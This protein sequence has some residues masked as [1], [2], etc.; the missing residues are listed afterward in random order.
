MAFKRYIRKHGKKLG[1]YYYENV[2]GNDGSVKTIYLGTNPSHHAKHR[3][4]KPLFFLILVLLLILVFGASLFLLQNKSY[5]IKKVKSQQADFDIDQILLK[6][7][8]KSNEFIEKQ[9]RI[10]NT[11]SEQ[12]A[13]SIEVYGLSDIIKT[14]SPSFVIKPGQTKVVNL[15]FSSYIAEQS[16]EQHPGVY[17]G[18]LAVKSQKA[19][20]EV[21]IVVE[22]ETKNVLFDMNLNPVALERKVKQGADTTI[23]V[24]L[25][26]LQ[27]IDSTNVDVGYSV[28]DMDGNTIVT[29]SETVVV[30]TQASFF[31]TISIPEKLKPGPYAFASEAKFGNS[32]GTSSYLFEVVGPEQEASFAQFCKNSVLCMGLSLTTILLLFAVMA[33]FY[34][35]IGAYLY[36]KIAG[37][38]AV[39]RRKEKK[40][41]ETEGGVEEQQGIFEKI[42]NKFSEFK[43]RRELERAGKKTLERKKE[44]KELAEEEK[45]RL[46]R[47]M[48]EAKLKRQIE[49]EEKQKELQRTSEERIAEKERIRQEWLDKQLELEKQRDEEAK[50]REEELLRKQ[51]DLERENI[52]REK[53]RK[54]EELK[55]QK[56]LEAQQRK[57]RQQRLWQ[58]RKAKIF[59]ALHKIGLYKTPEEKRMIAL[60]KDKERWEKLRK[61]E[62]MKRQKEL[63]YK[64]SEEEKRE[65]EEQRLKERLRMQKE[66]EEQ[67]ALEEKREREEQ[68]ELRRKKE[69]EAKKIEEKKAKLESQRK[70]LEAETRRK[71]E[72]R[73]QEQL[74]RQRQLEK[75]KGIGEQKK[76]KERVPKEMKA[77][78]LERFFKKKKPDRGL[79]EAKKEPK[80]ETSIEKAGFFA[81][82]FEKPKSDTDKLED[83]IKGLGLFREIEKGAGKEIGLSKKF[84]KK[85]KERF[86]EEKPK[87]STSGESKAF[88]GCDKA[89]IDAKESI[90]KG[91]MPK[92][93]E[94]YIKARNGYLS[95]SRQEKEKFYDR[96]MEVYNLLSK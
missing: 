7:L 85:E 21:P 71:E 56:A 26:N 88:E 78:L 4:R 54:E 47:E 6:V 87:I 34:F 46:E 82:L 28:K 25:F 36:E 44:L 3:I 14:D 5:L 55:K 90:G 20:K 94:F 40:D 17:V 2:R 37:L 79:K 35:F 63:E 74:K 89:L 10:M 27:S 61:Q 84:G 96:L 77:G 50:K 11:G 33:Y 86:T 31:K 13:I 68:E 62:E 57:E 59:D 75:Q 42:K 92:A 24:R 45:R 48:M 9:V 12:A 16:I 49:L 38:A 41:I 15:N 51:Q 30:K 95:L 43:A 29:E 19:G 91:D 65:Q 60:Q 1:P 39:P 66:L 53:R 70:E 8:I 83:A 52:E 58:E 81:K 72:L 22:I 18:K 93:K 73:R 80:K 76:L 32:I 23:E 69:L 64:K 67:R